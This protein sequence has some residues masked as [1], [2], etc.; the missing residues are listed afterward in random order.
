VER[1]PARPAKN[2]VFR[3]PDWLWNQ[4]KQAAAERGE[5]VS[6]VIRDALVRYVQRFGRGT[7]SSRDSSDSSSP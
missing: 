4:A 6:D 7:P 3:V 2:R 5:T 1:H